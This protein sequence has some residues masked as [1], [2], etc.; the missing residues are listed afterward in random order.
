MADG[1]VSGKNGN[2]SKLNQTATLLHLVYASLLFFLTVIGSSVTVYLS[3]HDD[4]QQIKWQQAQSNKEAISQDVRK[5]MEDR[6]T[7]LEFFAKSSITDRENLHKQMDALSQ[8]QQELTE[9]L[10]RLE[11]RK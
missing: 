3:L 5:N 1:D 9:R 11:Y 6:I 4:V 8:K 10:T 2:G 7:S